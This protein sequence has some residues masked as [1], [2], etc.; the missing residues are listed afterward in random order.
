MRKW[1]W[2]GLALGLVVI[3]AV[4]LI[5]GVGKV[6]TQADEPP[7]G[8]EVP[9]KGQRSQE[10]V[11]AFNKGD[12]KAVAGFWTPDG[13]YI[14]QDGRHYK[15]R[16]AIEKL[17]AKLF[18][19][20]KG[21]KLT[22]TVTSARMVGTDLALEDGITEVAPADG[23]P[24]SAARFSAVLVKKEGAWYFE[25]VRE[26]D[27]V[28]PSHAEH[29]EPLEWLIGDWTGESEKGE[30]ATASYEWAEN[31]NFIVGSF[32]TTLNGVPVV[33]GDQWIGWD[34]VDKQIRSWSFY[35]GGGFS[36]S[37]W[38]KDGEKW[39][40]KTTAKT[41]DGKKVSMTNVLTKVD[42]DHLSWQATKV[43]VD[44]KSVP[45]G[46]LVKMKRVKEEQPKP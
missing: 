15:G 41:G 21:A 31:D 33:G 26:S 13:D 8:A 42:A 16:A 5:L 7:K 27:A 45:D 44:G 18:A 46:A 11:A 6:A 20:Q 12:A 28:P 19:E 38:T 4:G 3:L 36:E 29:F 24:P 25:S 14:D 30:S 10:F 1:R 23:G 22:V 40:I 35:S 34:A 39:T 32:A 2:F 17:F 37:T 9:G 43:S